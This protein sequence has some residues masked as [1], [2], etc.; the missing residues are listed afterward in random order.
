MLASKWR[1]KNTH[2][3]KSSESEPHLVVRLAV[4]LVQPLLPTLL[5]RAQRRRHG[6]VA[7][8]DG[9]KAKRGRGGSGPCEA[10]LQHAISCLGASNRSL[11]ARPFG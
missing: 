2:P 8:G 3:R 7:A 6:P 5:G 9:G 1:A 4:S 10:R 11:G